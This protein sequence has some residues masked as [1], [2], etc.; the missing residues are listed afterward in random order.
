M[1]P[2]IWQGDAAAAEAKK[3]AEEREAK[4]QEAAANAR[5]ALMAAG[6]AR[7]AGAAA[8][9][10]GE[11]PHAAPAAPVLLCSFVHHHCR[12]CR[13]AISRRP[14]RHGCPCCA[15]ASAPH[16]TFPFTLTPGEDADIVRK[17]EEETAARE[18]EIA[19][20]EQARAEQHT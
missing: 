16:D 4:V 3:S 10:A 6:A 7:A 12:R 15:L 17:R 14:R 5:A 2:S 9:F 19:S 20:E 11:V 18:A 1:F 13:F 8:K